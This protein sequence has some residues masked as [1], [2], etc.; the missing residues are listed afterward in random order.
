MATLNN[1]V[2]APV[3][4][5]SILATQNAAALASA[6]NEKEGGEAQS[7][8]MNASKASGQKTTQSA[9]L[10]WDKWEAALD[11]WEAAQAVY[12]AKIAAGEDA[13]EPPAYPDQ[14]SCMLY[15]LT[16][17]VTGKG[18]D[19][20]PRPDVKGLATLEKL[21]T[22]HDEFAA[23][24]S[25]FQRKRDALMLE[26]FGLSNADRPKPIQNE[27][28]HSNFQAWIMTRTGKVSAD[29]TNQIRLTHH[30]NKGLS[31]LTSRGEI[32]TLTKVKGDYKLAIIQIAT[33]G[34]AAL[35]API[36]RF[37]ALRKAEMKHFRERITSA[38]GED[39]ARNIYRAPRADNE[40]VKALTDTAQKAAEKAAE[41]AAQINALDDLP[42]EGEETAQVIDAESVTAP[43]VAAPVVEVAP[44]PS[45]APVK[46][47][48]K[49]KPSK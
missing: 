43:V 13:G 27:A 7:S 25:E 4:I 23:I 38:F 28:D 16:V 35:N 34:M 39:I 14:T 29:Q 3:V 2:S 37:D 21:Q 8:A 42:V 11:A 18:C 20:S 36:R 12:A 32:D 15:T 30:K 49:R 1:T 9:S 44:E 48:A 41:N 10:D 22:M 46:A 5:T 17:H 33:D 26:H 47:T 24:A 31:F 45:A 6:K 19:I 40:R